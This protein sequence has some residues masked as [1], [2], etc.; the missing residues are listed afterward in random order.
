MLAQWKT[1][2]YTAKFSGRL[3]SCMGKVNHRSRVVTYSRPLWARA[4]VKQRRETVIHEVAHAIVACHHGREPGVS[5]GAAWKSQMRKMGVS[6][7]ARCHSVDRTGL[8]RQRSDTIAIR[9]CGREHRVTMKRLRRI[10]LG[11][12][13]C[14][15]GGGRLEQIQFATPQ[16]RDR[17]KRF[18]TPNTPAQDVPVCGLERGRS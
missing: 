14:K 3:T 13:Q 15:C 6:S 7:P 2:G 17:Y 4:S 9:C 11:G 12:A 8:K 10:I 16:D 1:P 18:L 5:H